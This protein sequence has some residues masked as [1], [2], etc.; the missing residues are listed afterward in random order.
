MR[1]CES[2]FLFLDWRRWVLSTNQK[3]ETLLQFSLDMILYLNLTDLFYGVHF[4]KAFHVDS[5]GALKSC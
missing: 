3:R 4:R 1:C 2:F 5:Y